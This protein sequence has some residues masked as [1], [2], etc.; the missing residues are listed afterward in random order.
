MQRSGEGRGGYW[1]NVSITR[2]HCREATR[3]PCHWARLL[4]PRFHIRKSQH[5]YGIMLLCLLQLLF[6]IIVVML[7]VLCSCYVVGVVLCLL[8]IAGYACP[9]ATCACPAATWCSDVRGLTPLH[10]H[11]SPTFSLPSLASFIQSHPYP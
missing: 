5:Y 2:L 3:L 10:L 9:A 4:H 8:R 6:V 11:T 7:W 1:V